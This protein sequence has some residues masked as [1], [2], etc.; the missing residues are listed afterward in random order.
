[1]KGTVTYCIFSG[2]NSLYAKHVIPIDYYF[3]NNENAV[4]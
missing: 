4:L 1:M 2:I 3:L